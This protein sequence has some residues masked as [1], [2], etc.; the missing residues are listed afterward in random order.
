M[1]NGLYG[2]AVVGHFA[3]Y[4]QRDEMDNSTILE[5]VSAVNGG[6]SYVDQSIRRQVAALADDAIARHPPQRPQLRT[7]V[8]QAARR[9]LRWARRK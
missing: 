6:L 7:K 9:L 3:F 5:Q 2:G 8:R 1:S 4:S